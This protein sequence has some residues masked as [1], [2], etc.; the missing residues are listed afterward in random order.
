MV[1][2]FLERWLILLKDELFN[3]KDSNKN[4]MFCLQ[5]AVIYFRKNYEIGQC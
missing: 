3:A 4:L 1:P 2:S 5:S